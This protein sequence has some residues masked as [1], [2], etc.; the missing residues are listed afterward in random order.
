M[1]SADAG[2]ALR[3]RGGER[4]L[5]FAILAACLAAILPVVR[6]V[7]PGW[8]LVAALMLA[9][10]V[11]GAGYAARTYRLPAVAVAL[12]E[13]GVWVVFITLIFLRDTALLWVI[14]TIDTV[15]AVPL[16]ASIHR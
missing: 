14:P 5:T 2:R 4:L 6:V 9:A 3:S 15:R 8:W 12:I 16:L 7:D 13:A 11:L 10:L 1:A